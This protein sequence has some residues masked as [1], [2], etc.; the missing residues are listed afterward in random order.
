[1]I[2]QDDAKSTGEQMNA[3]ELKNR[4]EEAVQEIGEDQE[5]L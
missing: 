4:E 5:D 2:A 3:E 1:L